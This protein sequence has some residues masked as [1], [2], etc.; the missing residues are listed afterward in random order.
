MA[1][2]TGPQPLPV[3]LGNHGPKAASFKTQ[4]LPGEEAAE[5]R[6]AEGDYV[7]SPHLHIPQGKGTQL[8]P[9]QAVALMGILT[10]SWG[11]GVYRHLSMNSP[12]ASSFL[13]SKPTL[14]FPMM[15]DRELGKISI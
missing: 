13:A 1:A 9:I 10:P 5:G 15:S 14:G 3:G 6:E 11:S 12:L 8:S 2:G 7:A 4:R